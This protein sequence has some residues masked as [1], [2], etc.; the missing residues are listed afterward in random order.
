MFFVLSMFFVDTPAITHLLC[1]LPWN[2]YKCKDL[3]GKALIRVRLGTDTEQ[4]SVARRKAWPPA[5]LAVLG[6]IPSVGE[7]FLYVIDF[8]CTN[9]LIITFPLSRYD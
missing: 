5:D 7:F 4:I 3:E 1:C 2:G 9:A 8:N 6:L